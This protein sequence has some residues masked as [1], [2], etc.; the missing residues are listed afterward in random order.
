MKNYLGKFSSFK[1]ELGHIVLTLLLLVP[2]YGMLSIQELSICFICGLAIDIDHI[3]NTFICKQVMKIPNYNGTLTRGDRGF[4]P[5]V[6][7]G[8]DVALVVG[9][10]TSIYVSLE[11]GSALLVVLI[12]HL[13]WDFIIYPVKFSWLFL[14]A[15]ASKKFQVGE[16]DYL[17]GVIFDTDSLKY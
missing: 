7:H 17:I 12:G 16:R 11:F 9:I 10:L 6:F 14:V 2:F 4:S 5:H 3:F 8:L 13:L 1:D 15:R